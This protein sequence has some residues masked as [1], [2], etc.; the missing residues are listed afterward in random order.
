MMKSM[1]LFIFYNIHQCVIYFFNLLK[2][3]QLNY[4]IYINYMKFRSNINI[5]DEL[6]K[7]INIKFPL[8]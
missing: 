4:Y 1:N 8:G 3:L 7:F 2:I 6:T 5:V